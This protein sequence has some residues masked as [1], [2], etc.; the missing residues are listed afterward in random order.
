MVF[1]ADAMKSSSIA[2]KPSRHVDTETHTLGIF[3]TISK[4]GME[5]LCICSTFWAHVHVHVP[6]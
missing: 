2:R 3:C 4:L 5:I 6:A 1:I